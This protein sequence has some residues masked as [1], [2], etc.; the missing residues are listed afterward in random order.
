MPGHFSDPHHFK[1][2]HLASLTQ[3]PMVMTLEPSP[4]TDSGSGPS[5]Y[6]LWPPFPARAM[7]LPPYLLPARV[8]D[9]DGRR[10]VT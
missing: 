2:S 5:L 9:L 7:Q 8:T 3:R 6:S 4:S 10:E 1:V